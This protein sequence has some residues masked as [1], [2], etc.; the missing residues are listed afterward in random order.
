MTNS[1]GAEM[2][3]EALPVEGAVLVKI[4]ANRDER[5]F[6]AR[7]FCSREFAAN[8][9]SASLVQASI[10]YNELRGT[11]RGMHFQWPHSREDKLVRCIRGSLLD[12]LLDLRPNSGSYLQHCSVR[13]DDEQRD[14]VFIPHGV[15]HGF[16][17]LAGNTEVLYQMTDF[18]APELGAGVRWDDSAFG[19]S[20][21]LPPA[22]ISRRDASYPDF[23]RVQ[24]EA[25][26]A[27][28]RRAPVAT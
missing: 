19:I 9:L 4:E 7:T 18:F 26:F 3:F 15:A 20:W 24:Y 27:E 11:V 23:D 12:V 5:G 16:Q 10:S 17:T 13:L 2:Q 28:R 25:E 8:G 22:M 1:D 14:A 21:P 6:F